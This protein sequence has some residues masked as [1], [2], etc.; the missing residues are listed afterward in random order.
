[1]RAPYRRLLAE[2]E[3]PLQV[4]MSDRTMREF[5]AR[6][7]GVADGR[8]GQSLLRGATRTPVAFLFGLTALVVLITCANLAN[9]LLARGA[10]RGAEMAVR[11]SLGARRAQVVTQLLV[12]SALLAALGGALSLLVA[13]G[14]L[15]AVA[16]FI[17]TGA[18]GTGTNLSLEIRR[19]CS[20]SRGAC[21]SGRRWCSG[22]SRRSTPRAP[23]S[24]PRSARAPARSPARTAARARFRMGLV[25]AQIALSTALLVSAGLFV[26]SLRNVSRVDLGLR[27]ENVVSFAL[28]PALNGYDQPRSDALHRRVETE[29]AALP[30]V[31]SVAARRLPLLDGDV[32]RRQRARRRLP[33]GPDTDANTRSARVGARVPAHAG[34]RAARRPRVSARGPRRARRGWRS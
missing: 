31:T 12:E 23:T 15:A 20:C 21:R 14:T 1:M 5:L 27:A 22:S 7:L 26:K 6:E 28:V 29:L 17:P 18:L 4:G 13:R 33:R 3:A 2:V 19:R 24:S 16:S 9:L 30:G 34:H 25:T 11:L 10:A 32:E 8:R